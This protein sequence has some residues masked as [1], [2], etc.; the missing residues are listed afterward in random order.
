MEN[1]CQCKLRSGYRTALNIELK[2]AFEER[3]GLTESQ[4]TKAKRPEAHRR[5]EAAWG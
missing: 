5:K 4:A 2:V 1:H 3:P